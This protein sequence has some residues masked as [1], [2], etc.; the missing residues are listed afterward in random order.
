M[1]LGQSNAK[2]EPLDE[3]H[4][5]A[6]IYCAGM[7]KFSEELAAPD[8]P[9]G[10]VPTDNVAIV[11]I[12]MASKAAGDNKGVTGSAMRGEGDSGIC[13]LM[14]ALMPRR[15]GMRCASSGTR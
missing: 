4:A 6:T 5:P 11:E 3:A 14:A 1:H 13:W 8:S 15:C 2:A 7:L 10:D 9:V 12:D